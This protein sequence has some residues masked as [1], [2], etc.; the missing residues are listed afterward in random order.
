MPK[1]IITGPESSGKTTLSEQISQYFKV[2]KNLEYAR[3]YL[4]K[5]NRQYNKDDLLHIAKQQLYSENN[6]KILD[7][8]LITI[9]I[10]SE[11]KY[12]ECHQWIKDQ[13]SK[14]KDEDRIYLLCKPDIK[15]EKDDLREHPFSRNEIYQLY[16]EE[17]NTLNHR[18]EIIDK[19][20]PLGFYKK[21]MQA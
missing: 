17:L 5:L 2:S 9:K 3:V 11:Y 21:Y 7:T 12:G 6:C 10:W 19:R 18:Y 20:N 4:S 16:E 15:W 1:I 8:D 14:Q 13:I